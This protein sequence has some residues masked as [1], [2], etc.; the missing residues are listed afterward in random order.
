MSP[1]VVLDGCVV[2]TMD[3]RHGEHVAGHVV[4]EGERISAVAGPALRGLP[5]ARYDRSMIEH[6]RVVTA[7]ERELAATAAA[8]AHQ[9]LNRAGVT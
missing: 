6:G 8:A 3:A 7:V 1:P 5:G 4:I 9:L 2:V